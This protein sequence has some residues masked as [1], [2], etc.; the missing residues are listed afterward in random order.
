MNRFV[1]AEIISDATND[2][3]KL[4]KIDITKTEH[5][6]SYKD[7]HIGFETD[8]DVKISEVSDR[9]KFELC[10]ECRTFLVTIVS[11]FKEKCPISMSMSVW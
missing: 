9:M 11:K 1:K 2:P 4:V 3:Y 7:L 8:Y 6:K 5:L 10:Q